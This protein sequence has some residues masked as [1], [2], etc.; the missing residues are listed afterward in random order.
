[1]MRTTTFAAIILTAGVATML[2]LDDQAHQQQ[3]CVEVQEFDQ[4]TTELAFHYGTFKTGLNRTLDELTQ[5]EIKLAD[6][7][8][9]VRALAQRHAPLFLERI[10]VSDHGNT[11]LARVA[12]NLV[13]HVE[14]LAEVNP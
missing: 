8:A 14:S 1:M 10:R 4:A 11:E 9:R 2:R 6:A 5:R 13:G 12:Q 7:A 3:C